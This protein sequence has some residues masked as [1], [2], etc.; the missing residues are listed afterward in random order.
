MVVKSGFWTILLD[1][2]VESDLSDRS[3]MS[4]KLDLLESLDW[5]GEF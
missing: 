3:D 4:D 5:F 2:I 1:L